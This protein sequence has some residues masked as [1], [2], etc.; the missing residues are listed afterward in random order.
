[1]FSSKVIS[2]FSSKFDDTEKLE[3]TLEENM[4]FKRKMRVLT[5]TVL[6]IAND[7]ISHLLMVLFNLLFHCK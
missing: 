1:M 4:R 5:A 3:I 2:S 6:T 7:C